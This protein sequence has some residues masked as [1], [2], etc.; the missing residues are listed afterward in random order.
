MTDDLDRLL[1]FAT[2]LPDF[3]DC[4]AR[5]ARDSEV[6]AQGMA[7][8]RISY[9]PDPR[10][11]L[12]TAAGTGRAD[13]VAGFVH[14]GYWRALRAEDH[15]FVLPALGRLCGRVANLEYRLMPGARMDD[16]VADVTAGLTR[17]AAACPK[18]RLLIL[19]HSAGAHL[20]T[21]ALA[22]SPELRAATAGLVPISGAFDLA[23]IARSFLQ[24]ELALTAPEI[25][26][27]SVTRLPDC[28]CLLAVGGAETRPFHDQ[29]RALAAT[30]PDAAVLTATGA[31]HMNV[32]HRLL[33]GPAPLVPV[34]SQWLEGENLPQLLETPPP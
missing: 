7:L 1:R 30:R 19:G 29:A 16:L 24:A 20:A 12:E 15:R 10:Q 18:A 27:H 28:P 34:L 32:L 6:A 4:Q 23:L 5:M 31:H 9:G 3:A 21:R 25:A 2:I 22:S 13:L 8:R 14:G 33:T 17:L 11:W 26:C